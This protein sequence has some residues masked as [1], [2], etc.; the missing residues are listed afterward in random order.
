L[1]QASHRRHV[2]AGADLAA[3]LEV[4]VDP[5]GDANGADAPGGGRGRIAG[6]DELAELLRLALLPG[7]RAAGGVG[8]IGA[9]RDHPLEA[10]LRRPLVERL[11]VA[12]DVVAVLERRTAADMPGEQPRQQLLAPFER[13]P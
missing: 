13:Y 5:F 7:G 4:A 12:I 11:A 10:D 6:D 2:E 8:G 1:Q 9:L 3:I